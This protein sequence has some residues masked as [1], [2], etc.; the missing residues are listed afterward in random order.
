MRRRRLIESWEAE[1]DS[2]NSP[3]VGSYEAA[4]AF[5]V[6]SSPTP[7]PQPDD[8]ACSVWLR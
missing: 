7:I 5:A 4:T 8:P 6:T 3:M 1:P 2:C